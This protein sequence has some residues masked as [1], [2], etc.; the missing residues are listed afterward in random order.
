VQAVALTGFLRLGL[1]F[2]KSGLGFSHK[3]D[4]AD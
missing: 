2:I 4:E 3:D 1:D